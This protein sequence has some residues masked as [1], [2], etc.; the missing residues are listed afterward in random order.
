MAISDYMLM[1]AQRSDCLLAVVPANGISLVNPLR[2]DA[3]LLQVDPQ[4]A[5]SSPAERSGFVQ[6][7]NIISENGFFQSADPTIPAAILT[8]LDMCGNQTSKTFIAKVCCRAKKDGKLHIT[9][10]FTQGFYPGGA[11]VQTFHITVWETASNSHIH[12]GVVLDNGEIKILT[13]LTNDDFFDSFHV[14]SVVFDY[15]NSNNTARQIIYI[16]GKMCNIGTCSN[17]PWHTPITPYSDMRVNIRGEIN[18][19][20]ITDSYLTWAIVFDSA[21]PPEEIQLFK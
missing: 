1:A 10:I 21:L 12:T 18:T 3:A 14:I 17:L 9:P 19:Q 2:Q 16:D 8:P 7:Q 5:D 4:S 11:T 13:A 20:Y 15:N 6:R